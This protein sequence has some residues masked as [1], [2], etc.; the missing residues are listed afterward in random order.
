[1][2]VVDTNILIYAADERSGPHT[3][4]AGLLSGWRGQSGAW[5]ATWPIIYEFLRVVSHPRLSPQPWQVSQAWGFVQA[6]LESRGFDLLTETDRHPAVVAEVLGELP[7]LSGRVLH[8][9]HIA[10]LMREHGI[11]RIYT[12]DRDFR[13]FPF[14]EVIDPLA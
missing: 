13:L 7:A 10:I 3:A 4:C 8:D 6:L 11:R 12:R 5:Y 9:A 2:F 1:M 14:I